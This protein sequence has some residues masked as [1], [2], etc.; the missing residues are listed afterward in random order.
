VLGEALGDRSLVVGYWLPDEQ[1]YVDD[2]GRAVDLTPPEPGRVATPITHGGAPLAVLIH[3][4]SVLDDP[5]LVDAVAAAARLAVSNA[6]MQSE[7][8]ERVAALTASRRRIVEAADA[9]RQ[10]LEHDL[11]DGVQRRLAT[12]A[13]TLGAIRDRTNADLL[14]ALNRE[15]TDAREEL[16]EFARGLHPRALTEDGLAAAITALP[17]PLERSV[18][19]AV[20]T[21]PIPQTVEAVIYFVCTE[22]LTNTAK[23]AAATSVKV[24]ITERNRHISATIE[25]D[26]VGGADP[27]NGSGLRG[28][29]DRVEAIGGN[30]TVTERPE[31]GTRL[32][33]TIPLA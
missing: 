31:G 17:S 20:S 5:G 21:S 24:D 8:R 3:D 14:D 30:L 4:V 19:V 32:E 16:A 28:L 6:R 11:R 9:Q 23:H 22:A 15:L 2:I 10:H 7:A 18:E 33:A 26:G 1:R 12:V 25:D 29:V 27:R 13:G